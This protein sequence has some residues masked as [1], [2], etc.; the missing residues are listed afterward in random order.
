ME[1]VEDGG[2]A[3]FGVVA[4]GHMFDGQSGGMRRCWDG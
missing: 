3:V 2:K 4:D 1:D